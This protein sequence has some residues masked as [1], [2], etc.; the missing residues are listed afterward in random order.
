MMFRKN[1]AG[2]G[3]RFKITQRSFWNKDLCIICENKRR[4][5][6]V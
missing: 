3:K 4:G 6:N 2:C 1:C 5:K